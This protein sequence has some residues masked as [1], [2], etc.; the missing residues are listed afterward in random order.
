MKLVVAKINWHYSS[1]TQV[2]ARLLGHSVGEVDAMVLYNSWTDADPDV[3][4]CAAETHARVEPFDFG[5]RPNTGAPRSVAMRAALFA[6][7]LASLPAAL[8]RCRPYKPDIV[9]SCQQKTDCLAA[10]WLAKKL[11]CP[12]VIHL[13]Y[14]IGPWLGKQTIHRLRHCDRVIAVSRFIQGNAIAHGV[15]KP[16]IDTVCNPVV[17]IPQLTPAERHQARADMGISDDDEVVGMVGRLDQ[18]K[19]QA[20]LIEAFARVTTKRPRSHLVLVGEGP[21][22]TDLQT[23]AQHRGLAERVHFTGQVNDITPLLAAMDVFC[24]PSREEAFGLT[25]AEASSAGLPVVAYNEGAIPEIVRNDE[26]GI[27]VHPND[28]CRLSEAIETLLDDRQQAHHMGAV[29]KEWVT[30]QFAPE[31]CARVFREALSHVTR[32]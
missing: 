8:Q 2:M 24:H 32:G 23:T 30:T 7:F 26:S 29:G 15:P 12:Q 17:P 5:Y 11:N 22:H 18:V 13:H 9:Y 28:V 21:A 31:R 10:T 4:R 3:Q 19:G 16:R 6:R 20:E 25:V 27:L 1:E 14:P